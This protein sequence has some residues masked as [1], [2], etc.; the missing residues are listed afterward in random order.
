M[1]ETITYTTRYVKTNN[2]SLKIYSL[3]KQFVYN[4]H[5]LTDINIFIRK[6]ITFYK[7]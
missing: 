6:T 1:Y 3:E 4:Q 7:V 2:E 5:N